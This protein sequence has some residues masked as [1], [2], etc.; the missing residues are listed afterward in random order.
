MPPKKAA[1]EWIEFQLKTYPQEVCGPG[2]NY[3]NTR[4]IV[5]HLP[6]LLKE[7]N[8]QF[9]IDMG[10]GQ[11]T[12]MKEVLEQTDI[13]YLGIDVNEQMLA[14]NR[15]AAKPLGERV[16]FVR[17]S[18][19][20]PQDSLPPSYP[21]LNT[22]IIARDV[23]IHEL[24]EDIP[25]LVEKWSQ[26]GKYLLTTHLEGGRNRAKTYVAINDWYYTATNMP[27][28]LKKQPVGSIREDQF[29]KFLHVYE[30]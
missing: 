12:W 15:E 21:V 5:K 7:L 13:K 20:D 25:P 19:H 14:A 23:L 9:L 17:G 16:A 18:I 1:E 28:L 2:S 10:C 22:G 26:L 29:N 8:I 3:K 4:R 6:P 24:P 27:K 11:F 30:F